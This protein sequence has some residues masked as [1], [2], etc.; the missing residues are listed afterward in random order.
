MYLFSAIALPQIFNTMSQ[1]VFKFLS[2][3]ASSDYVKLADGDKRSIRILSQPVMGFEL[4]T[5]GKPV[6]WRHDQAAPE[7][8]SSEER[9]RKFL[10]F[11]VYEYDSAA[12]KVWQ[13]G[14]RTIIDQLS[15]LFDS[16]EHWSSFELV[17]SRR[18]S[19]M[20]T[21][22]S[23]VGIGRQPEENLIS[24]AAEAEQYVNLD[25]L[26]DGGSPFI[27]E[28]P[29]LGVEKAEGNTKKAF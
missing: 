14:Q 3:S 16:G 12:V 1:D 28:L 9:P 5:E 24:F 8:P 29:Q 4:F 15:Q 7:L 23:V 27:K 18:G 6:R 22:Y 19:G 26:F 11:I 25:A 17:L 13:F 10:A 21:K 2:K 20:E